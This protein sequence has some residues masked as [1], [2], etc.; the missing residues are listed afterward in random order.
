MSVCAPYPQ[1]YIWLLIKIW[2]QVDPEQLHNLL[3]S[4]QQFGPTPPVAGHPV[5]KVVFRLDALLLVLKSCQGKVCR[6]PWKSLHPEGN[7]WTLKHALAQEFDHF[8]EVEQIRTRYN[9]CENGYLIEAEGPMW[10]TH[11]KL[12]KRHGLDWDVWT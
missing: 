2:I 6:E 12:Y 10:E 11:G 8:Y 9:H 4:P 1:K 3:R 7:V 5:D